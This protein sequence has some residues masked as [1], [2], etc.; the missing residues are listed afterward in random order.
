MERDAAV[1]SLVADVALKLTSS[2]ASTSTTV[3]KKEIDE[4]ESRR[5]MSN[6]FHEAMLLHWFV[7]GAGGLW[8]RMSEIPP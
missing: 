3:D 4:I 1:R 8:F 6:G 2:V 5:T 7:F